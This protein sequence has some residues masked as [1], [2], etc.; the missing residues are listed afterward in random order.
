MK[1]EQTIAEDDAFV[2]YS[3]GLYEALAD[4]LQN[5]L[6]LQKKKAPYGNL[7]LLHTVLVCTDVLLTVI[8]FAEHQARKRGYAKANEV[9]NMLKRT[10]IHKITDAQFC[11]PDKEVNLTQ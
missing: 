7:L 1:T 8:D 5:R 11:N 10:A 6:F 9:H 4:T 2:Q 3:D